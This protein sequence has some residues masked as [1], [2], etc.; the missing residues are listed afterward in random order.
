MRSLLPLVR[1]VNLCWHEQIRDW[2]R[3]KMKRREQKRDWKSD[4]EKW[5]EQKRANIYFLFLGVQNASWNW[6]ILFVSSKNF[7]FPF[8]KKILFYLA[9]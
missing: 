3:I 7:A 9:Q 5:R 1:R 4:R 2:K 8:W 6:Y